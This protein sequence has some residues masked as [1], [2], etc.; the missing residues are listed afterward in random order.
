MK[1]GNIKW[2]KSNAGFA[3]MP[4][5][6]LSFLN[7]IVSYLAMRFAFVSKDVLDIATGNQTGSL[8]TSL[9]VLC[10]LISSYI[11][12]HITYSLIDVKLSC[13]ITNKLSKSFTIKD[14]TGS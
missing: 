13:T 1:N 7:I 9:F 3:A 8:K 4:I 14:S 12:I 2:L 11:I 6:F 5:I 10:A